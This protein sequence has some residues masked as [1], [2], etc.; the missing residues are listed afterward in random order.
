MRRKH[1]PF[2]PR[3]AFV[4]LILCVAALAMLA[5]GM[6]HYNRWM[7]G[8]KSVSAEQS[9]AQYNPIDPEMKVRII[10]AARVLFAEGADG[11]D[12]CSALQWIDEAQDI[13]RLF[14]SET[15][16]VPL[17]WEEAGIDPAAQIV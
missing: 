10:N 7:E 15:S 16:P 14:A 8:R 11:S 13:I 1:D 4:G 2:S 5:L 17:K 3:Q 12:L 6:P 9:M